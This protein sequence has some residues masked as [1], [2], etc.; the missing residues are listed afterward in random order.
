VGEGDHY[1]SFPEHWVQALLISRSRFL[2]LA[3]IFTSS[4]LIFELWSIQDNGP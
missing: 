4:H 1:S 2:G 3:S